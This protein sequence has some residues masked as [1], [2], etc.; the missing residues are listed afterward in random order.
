MN[1]STLP[2]ARRHSRV[3]ILG[4]T[5]RRSSASPQC[6]KAKPKKAGKQECLVFRSEQCGKAEPQ[7]TQADD[8]R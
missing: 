6:D 1:T 2:E 7:K 4:T 3:N 5:F 8:C